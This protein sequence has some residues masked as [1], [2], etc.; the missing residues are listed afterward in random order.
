M[1]SSISLHASLPVSICLSPNHSL[2]PPPPPF[3]LYPHFLRFSFSHSLSFANLSV[4]IYFPWLSLF[5]RLLPISI[6][7][8][9]YLSIYLSTSLTLEQSWLDKNSLIALAM[10]NRSSLDSLTC[11]LDAI[12]RRE[13]ERERERIGGGR[14]ES[15]VTMVLCHELMP[16]K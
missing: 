9:I 10:T 3:V 7:L 15:P 1:H 5:Y 2:P 8:P 12:V 14:G 6:Y 4:S 13:R 16:Y 11:H